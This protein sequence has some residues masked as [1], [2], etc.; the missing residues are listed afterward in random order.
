[1]TKTAT[2]SSQNV[3]LIAP[4][5]LPGLKS[6]R[7]PLPVSLLH[8]AA[9]LRQAGHKPTILDLSVINVP[10]KTESDAHYL[11]KI[12]ETV[13]KTKPSIIG[14]NCFSSMHFPVVRKLAEGI[15]TK[16][17]DIPICLGGA[18][19]TFFPKEILENCPEFDFIVTGEGEMQIIALANIIASGKREQLKD[20]QAFCYRDNGKI[21]INPRKEFMMNLDDLPPPAYD[22][23]NFPDYYADHSN[24]YSPKKREIKLSVP[25]YTTRSCPFNCSFCNANTIMGRRLRRRAPKRVVDEIEMLAR[26]FGQS[27]FSFTDDNVN[28]DKKHF[29]AICEDIYK[30]KLDVQLCIP[31]G[32]YLNAVDEDIVSTFVRAGGTTVSVPIESG[33]TFIRNKIIG[34][35]L[36]EETIYAAVKLLQKYDLFTVGLFIMGFAEDTTETLTDTLSMI[37]KLELDVN[38]VNTLIPFPATRVYDQASKDKLLLF[39]N[40]KIWT[41]ETFFD[42]LNKQD[43]FIKPY[44]ME[45]DELRRFRKIFDGLYIK[46]N[47]AKALNVHKS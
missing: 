24:W 2:V 31:Q 16:K 37:D 15:H 41:G 23:I 5:K 26:D 19:A 20:I 47:R 9:A 3:L 35:N 39:D 8:L 27:Y 14:I 40:S 7:G 28:V 21:V 30:R 46:S 29:I 10:P 44:N 1:M 43:F 4:H 33:N 12:C 25:I 34:K 6:S 38:G 45:I 42:P 13:D 36:T 18:H 11:S 32:F 17:P 22:M